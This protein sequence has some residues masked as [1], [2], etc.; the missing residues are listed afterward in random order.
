MSR[1]RDRLSS[2]VSSALTDLAS[3]SRTIVMSSPL[4]AAGS[5]IA[6]AGSDVIKGRKRSER[7]NSDV[8][9]FPASG[10]QVDPTAI[11]REITAGTSFE[12]D[13]P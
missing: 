1:R 4:A 3:A 6:A 10:A 13:E 11:F 5:R 12:H 8:V 2:R 7:E 9:R